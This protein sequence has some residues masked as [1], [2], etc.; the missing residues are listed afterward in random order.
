MVP[1][2]L[3]PSFFWGQRSKGQRSRGQKQ[4]FR[5][6]SIS[7]FSFLARA[8]KFSECVV[9][10]MAENSLGTEFWFRAPKNF[11]GIQKRS[12]LWTSDHERNLNW[13]D[14]C[15]AFLNFW[16]DIFFSDRRFA[17]KNTCW[18]AYHLSCMSTVKYRTLEE[19]LRTMF[20]LGTFCFQ[21]FVRD[22]MGTAI[23][24][25]FYFA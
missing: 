24:F 8:F 10:P 11:W 7:S 17:F 13:Q 19:I 12:N 3:C 6:K 21:C 14:K 23:K 20:T 22:T 5:L 4:G 18:E 9:L 15:L 1:Q 25:F 16:Q 2:G